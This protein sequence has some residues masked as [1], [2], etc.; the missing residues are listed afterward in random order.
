MKW[1]NV[2]VQVSDL[3]HARFY[4]AELDDVDLSFTSLA[5]AAFLSREGKRTATGSD[6]PSALKRI[7]FSGASLQGVDFSGAVFADCKFTDAI[8]DGAT[9]PDDLP[10][11]FAN[12][13]GMAS[14]CPNGEAAEGSCRGKMVPA[15]WLDYSTERL[16]WFLHRVAADI[17]NDP[18]RIGALETGYSVTFDITPPTGPERLGF[19]VRQSTLGSEDLHMLRDIVERHADELGLQSNSIYFERVIITANEALVTAESASTKEDFRRWGCMDPRVSAI[20]GGGKRSC[21]RDFSKCVI[22]WGPPSRHVS[23]CAWDSSHADE[24]L[25]YVISEGVARIVIRALG[26]HSLLRQLG[27]L[28]GDIVESD[29]SNTWPVLR[30]AQLWS[31]AARKR[32]TERTVYTLRVRR[33]RNMFQRT[34]EVVG[35]AP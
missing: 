18:S 31:E 6:R 17:M 13:L 28:A 11:D 29:A 20:F 15:P 30:H 35:R 23:M 34:I 25:E 26:K 12:V 3:Q 21:S 22:E 16:E 33:N 27:F 8:L 5:G 2:N 1:E 4:G 10:S 14:T 9:F 7:D 32:S 24:R 19:H